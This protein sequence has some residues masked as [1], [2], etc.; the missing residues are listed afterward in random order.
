MKKFS[1]NI[2]AIV[3]IALICMSLTNVVI[4]SLLLS[5]DSSQIMHEQIKKYYNTSTRYISDEIALHLR[6]FEEESVV[7]SKNNVLVNAIIDELGRDDYLPQFMASLEFPGLT[8]LVHVSLHD[9]EF[10]KIGEAPKTIDIPEPQFFLDQQQIVRTVIEQETHYKAFKKSP[11]YQTLY[12]VALPVNYE[13]RPEGV[14]LAILQWETLW[15]KLFGESDISLSLH[16]QQ[17]EIIRIGSMEIAG[18]L[19]SFPIPDFSNLTLMSKVSEDKI[20]NPIQVMEKRIWLSSLVLVI[21][22]V[23]ISILFVARWISHPIVELKEAAANVAK[24]TW[25]TVVLKTASKE[26]M[27]LADTFNLMTERLQAS[28]RELHKYQASL[29]RQVTTRTKE[30]QETTDELKKRTAQYQAI[31]E[32]VPNGIITINAKGLIQSFNAAAEQMFGYSPKEVFGKNVHML[33]PE[34][35]HSEHDGYLE[36]YQKTNKAKIIGVGREVT[37]LRKNGKKFPMYL[38]VGEVKLESESLFAGIVIDITESKQKEQELQEANQRMSLAADAAKFGVWDWDLLKNELIWDGWMYRLYG[39]EAD[40]FEG[41]YEAWEKG[42]HPEDL[43]RASKEINQAIHGEKDFDTNFRVIH[44]NGQIRHIKAAAIVMRDTNGTAFRMIGINFDISERISAEQD[45]RQAKEAAE[46]NAQKINDYAME[47]ELKN[48]EL[49]HSRT[50]A[51]SANKAKSQF[52]ANMSHEIRTPMNAV[53]GFS[54]L[55]SSLLTDPQHKSYIQ[56]IQTAGKSLLTLINDI[57][58][59]SKIEAGKLKIQYE[60]ISLSQLIEEIKQ[61]FNAKIQEKNLQFLVEIDLELPKSLMLDEVRIRQALINLIGNSLK[62]TETGHIKLSASKV[63]RNSDHSMLDLTIAVEDSGIGIP[64]DQQDLIF[65]SFRQQDGQSTR[66]FGGTGLGLNLTK[67]MVELMNGQISVDSVPGKGSIFRIVLQD[68]NVSSLASSVNENR[69]TF[70]INQYHFDSG[71]VLVVDDIQANRSLIRET[72]IR[73]GLEVLEADNGQN[74]L[75]VVEEYHPDLILMDIRMPVMD[76]YEA[77]RQLRDNPAT[78]DIPIIALTASVTRDQ[79]AIAKDYAFDEYLPKPV[80]LKE[81]FTQLTQH[82]QPSENVLADQGNQV[83]SQE[84]GS[85]AEQW[86]TP[87]E[88]MSRLENE[89]MKQWETVKNENVFDA[90]EAFGKQLQ[91]LGQEHQIPPLQDFGATL[92]SQAEIFDIE[93]MNLTLNAYPR[94]LE[95]LKSGTTTM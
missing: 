74:A 83:E 85:S 18:E 44:P 80:D 21:V 19:K 69:A 46:K 62:F 34:P 30:L 42:V 35:Y 48:L 8:N 40:Q 66:K 39:I 68:V 59:L 51:E 88:L 24:G 27:E 6:L 1:L 94:L 14:L 95:L 13:G 20:Q 67:K 82:F 52:L 78:A 71:C 56:S 32:T 60:P 70:D 64:P 61:I 86:E 93:G 43:D 65:E 41:A 89:I 63:Y 23:L 4:L 38:S 91:Q 92:Q 55:L 90:I 26:V 45:I 15:N 87:P 12:V 75:S 47:M 58:D 37:G 36:N 10:N 29:E 77:T 84:K 2:K 5:H 3:S 28:E 7:L 11:S 57:L 73:T 79:I 17:N 72:L 33:M 50:N 53:I 49:D 22:M 31:F 16:D 54:E 25:S 81:L 9:F 76:G